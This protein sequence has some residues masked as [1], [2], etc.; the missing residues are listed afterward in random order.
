[1]TRF[2]QLHVLTFYPP[3]NLNRDDAGR[4]KTAFL[5]GVER[6]RISSQSLKRAVRTSEAFKSTL[7]GHLG[8]RTQRLGEKIEGAL[9]DDGAAPE[10]ANAIAREIAQILG[11]VEDSAEPA[12]GKGKDK[13]A[14]GA[15]APLPSALT[16][17]LA[18]IGPQERAHAFDLARRKL[19]DDKTEIAA[20]LVLRRADSAADIAMF[21]RM[22]ADNPDFNREAAVQVAHA[23]TTH[24][25]AIE[26]DFY[27]AVDD[28]KTKAEDAGAGFMGELGFGAG[29]F[30]LYVCVDVA[31]L[32]RNLDGNE[33]L[34]QD[35]VAALIEGLATVSPTGKQASF[36]SR[37]RASYILAEKGDQ[38]PRTL[39][40]AFLRPVAGADLLDESIEALERTR[41]DM[42]AAY[43]ACADAHK[44]MNVRGRGA[45]LAEIKAFATEWAA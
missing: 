8:E 42:D 22:L 26:D 6:L 36:A 1:M 44:I 41:E 27:T 34:A 19:A 38:Q 45:T 23:V 40:A 33:E 43:G 3:S 4:P 14:K 9:L 2:I 37:A 24:K 30:Y 25:V 7:E 35:A 13:G 18:F 10:R 29:V 31:L 28:L 12:R 15:D 17:Q 20:D 16:R 21:G 5:G 11:K 32:N 39:A